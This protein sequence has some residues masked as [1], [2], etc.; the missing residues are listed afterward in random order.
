MNL[1][2]IRKT[3][4]NYIQRENFVCNYI[5]YLQ[6]CI[7]KLISH[8]TFYEV[9]L[10]KLNIAEQIFS[11]QEKHYRNLLLLLKPAETK[12]KSAQLSETTLACNK[13]LCQLLESVLAGLCIFD[14]KSWVYVDQNHFLVSP[15]R[16]AIDFLFSQGPRCNSSQLYLIWNPP[17]LKNVHSCLLTDEQRS[18]CI[19]LNTSNVANILIAKII[20]LGKREINVYSWGDG[21][22]ER[23]HDGRKLGIAFVQ[24]GSLW[25]I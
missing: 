21:Y 14:I 6:R 12:Q 19:N 18:S 13:A 15:Q 16:L 7:I 8:S 23:K 20:S 22:R 5:L 11:L 3:L 25:Y 2:K 17:Q 10:V 9:C 4:W 1:L 24:N